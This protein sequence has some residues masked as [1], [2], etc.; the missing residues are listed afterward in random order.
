MIITKKLINI[1]GNTEGI[2]VGKKIK[3]KQKQNNDVLFL[4]SELPR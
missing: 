1:N 4:P 2:T 3:T